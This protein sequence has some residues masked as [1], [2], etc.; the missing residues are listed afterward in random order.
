LAGV[1]VAIL[2][3]S[4][5]YLTLWTAGR[6]DVL[7]EVLIRQNFQ[8]FSNPWD[9]VAPFW[10]YVPYFFT[11][12]APWSFA[13]LLAWKLPR[14]TE[15]DRRL[16]LLSGVWI[17]TIIAFFSLSKSKRD[18]YIVPTAPAAAVLAAEAGLAW[19]DGR[20][21]PMRA[22]MMSCLRWGFVVLFAV[23]AAA[24]VLRIAPKYQGLKFV[25]Y[26]LAGVL[27]V[28]AAGLATAPR[29]R[30]PAALA[31]AMAAFYL[32][33][34]TVVLP[35][36]DEFKSARPF[37][38]QVQ[39]LLRP[40]DVVASYNF[41]DW[42]AEYR[43]YLGRPIENLPGEMPLRAAWARPE[44]VVL[45]VEGAQLDEARAVIGDR[46]PALSRAVG[47]QTVYVLTSR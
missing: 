35:A 8:R 26:M 9:H 29:R 23:A 18:P 13:A 1:G 46:A 10:Y 22:R 42:R 20:L 12:M 17:V 19:I 38:A 16:A 41:W 31:G 39:A 7:H 6:T 15:D 40:G 11:D 33:V 2:V 34:A 30:A 37:C 28:S 32:T 47:S 3:A 25:A 43:Y 44:R 36:L 21:S 14:E 24:L 5:W 27:G 4:P 45:L